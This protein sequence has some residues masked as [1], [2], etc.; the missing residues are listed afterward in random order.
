MVEANYGAKELFAV[1]SSLTR[2]VR[3][4]QQRKEF[5]RPVANRF[6]NN[7][8]LAFSGIDICPIFLLKSESSRESNIN[9]SDY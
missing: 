8:L 5:F 3:R 7:G 4:A 1:K 2:S 9:S 6:E